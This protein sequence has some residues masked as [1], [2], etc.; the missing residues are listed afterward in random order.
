[1]NEYQNLLNN[2]RGM[3]DMK[4]EATESQVLQEIADLIRIEKFYRESQ[5][6]CCDEG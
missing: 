6:G 4:P 1:M 5:C 2:L 3:L